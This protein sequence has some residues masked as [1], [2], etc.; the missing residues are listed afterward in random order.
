MGQHGLD[1]SGSGWGPVESSC[2]HGNEPLGFINA[3][4][5]F[6]SSQLLLLMDRREILFCMNCLPPPIIFF[7]R[8]ILNISILLHIAYVTY[9]ESWFL[10]SHIWLLSNRYKRK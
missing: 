5:S 6:G 8:H 4:E 3:V 10:M 1:E 9:A 2:E 7:A